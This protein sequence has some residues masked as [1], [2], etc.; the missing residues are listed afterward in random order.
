MCLQYVNKW[1]SLATNLVVFVGCVRL[2]S[3][4]KSVYKVGECVKL[5][6]SFNSNLCTTISEA[7]CVETTLRH[8][9]LK[10]LTT[11]IFSYWLSTCFTALVSNKRAQ[12]IV[13][14]HRVRAHAHEKHSDSSAKRA[15]RTR[16]G[17]ERARRQETGAKKRRFPAPPPR[18]SQTREPL[19]PLSS[20][21]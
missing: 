21:Y 13:C 20:V 14:C 6:Q 2:F 17:A 7:T 5:W 3:A 10:I 1:I 4:M 19:A 12:K 15:K 16:S 8:Y 18:R 9:K 11:D